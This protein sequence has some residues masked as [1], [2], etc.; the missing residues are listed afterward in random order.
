MATTSSAV[1][2]T[3]PAPGPETWTRTPRDT[4]ETVRELKDVLKA[5]KRY[6]PPPDK[7]ITP[8]TARKTIVVIGTTGFVGPHVVASLL[9]MHSRS[10]IFCINRNVDGEQRTL[11]ALRKMGGESVTAFSDLHFLATDI[12]RANMGLE[13]SQ[14]DMLACEVDEI[15]FN[16]WNPH[17]GL[18]LKNFRP[19]LDAICN[20]ISFCAS[21]PKR[22]RITFVSSICAVGEWQRNHPDQPLVPEE[23]AW[24]SAS[25]MSNG[26]GKSKFIAEQLLAQAHTD[27]GLP[28]AIVRPGQIGGSVMNI[29]QRNWPVQGWLYSVIKTSEKIGYW[30]T[31]VEPLDWIPVDVLSEGIANVT[32]CEVN[33]ASVQVFNMMHPYP[34]SW[35]LLFTTLQ[36]RFGLRAKE[37]SLPEWLDKVESSNLRLKITGFLRTFG[38]G[39]E[40][41]LPVENRKALEMLPEIGP[42]TQGC[43]A[44]WLKGWNLKL[45]EVKAKM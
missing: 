5:F 6:L 29:A 24:D 42:M 2:T 22:P 38:G 20:A 30:P 44:I 39:R 14:C 18:P 31:H 25:A 16:A 28:I 36:D 8:S 45:N 7:T 37:V 4:S 21:S 17:W 33:N 15:I 35:H 26:Y 12:S 32:R 23:V 10:R 1:I 9:R 27:L 11:S 13:P 19:L 3:Q 40:F 34:A 41:D 43:L